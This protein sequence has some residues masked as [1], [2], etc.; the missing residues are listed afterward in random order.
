MIIKVIGSGCANCK[1]L[2]Q[3]TKDAVSE[4]HRDDEIIYVTDMEDILATGIMRTPGLMIDGKIVS[5]G[6]VPSIKEIIE[7]IQSR[8]SE[9]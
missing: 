1:N 9:S 3:K 2:L 5:T 7:F 8:L 6:R 4:L